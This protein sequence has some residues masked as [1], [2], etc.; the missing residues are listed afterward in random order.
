[1]ATLVLQELENLP[2]DATLALEAG[3]ALG[4]NGQ[5]R[6]AQDVYARA[7]SAALKSGAQAARRIAM[8]SLVRL[9][10]IDE[11]ERIV[12]ERGDAAMQQDFAS[13]LP[14]AGNVP[15]ASR[16]IAAQRTR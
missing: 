9:H 4:L 10:R 3:H 6:K 12:A 16:V 13:A 7:P 1:M 14:D 5:T 11:P 15:R 8:L 2:A